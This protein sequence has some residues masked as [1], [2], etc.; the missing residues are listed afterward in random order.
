MVACARQILFFLIQFTCLQLVCGLFIMAK[1]SVSFTLSKRERNLKVD[2]SSKLVDDLCPLLVVSFISF[3][4]FGSSKTVMHL[5]CPNMC[6]CFRCCCYCFNL[7][8]VPINY[9]WL[10]VVLAVLQTFGSS[11][12]HLRAINYEAEL[13]FNSLSLPL[14]HQ[15]HTYRQ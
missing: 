5:P 4:V 13:L 3:A 10:C 2:E 12:A 1:Y 11:T 14:L 15:L 9:C 6:L 8:C 7:I